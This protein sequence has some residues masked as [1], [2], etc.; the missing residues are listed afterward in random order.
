[1]DQIKVSYAPSEEGWSN[2]EELIKDVLIKE[3]YRSVCEVGGGANPSLPLEFVTEHGIEY[4]ILDIS[5]EELN[6]APAAYTKVCADIE[7]LNFSP[8]GKYDLVF[9]RMLAEHV[10]SGK[11]FHRNVYNLL[12]SGGRAVHFF[13][14]LYAPAFVLNRLVPERF[15]SAFVHFLQPG[16]DL[17]G[18]QG[19]FPAY[20]SWCRGPTR[21]QFSRFE[22]LGFAVERYVGFFGYG[23]Y[24]R[25]VK[26]IWMLHLRLAE[27]LASHPLNQLTS[28]SWV[29]LRKP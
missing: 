4:S 1:M 2:F 24:Y 3:C 10:R 15:S 21:R 20:Y 27:W 8:H 6:K 29:I 14:T 11:K 18:R 23:G 25:K 13:P 28:F 7:G 19:K 22:R 26:P 12:R 17:S 9:T 5:Q 16:R